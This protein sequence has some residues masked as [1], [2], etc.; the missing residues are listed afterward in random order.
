MNR[1]EFN[2]RMERLEEELS[3]PSIAENLAVFRRFDKKGELPTDPALRRLVERR[4]DFLHGA[5][6]DTHPE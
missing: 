4:R 6:H 3:T 1:D 2:R 5:L